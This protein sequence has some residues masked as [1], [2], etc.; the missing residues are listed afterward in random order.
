MPGQGSTGI[1]RRRALLLGAAALGGGL[2]RPTGAALARDSRPWGPYPP[3]AIEPVADR[4]GEVVVEDPYRWLEADI[5]GSERLRTWTTAQNATADAYLGSLDGRD[6]IRARLDALFDIETVGPLSN[7]G[8]FQFF[9]RRGRSEEQASLWV[10]QG[11]RGEA[12]RL[13]D[14]ARWSDAGTTAL[15]GFAVSQN[16][17]YVAYAQQASGSD[18]RVWR[19]LDRESGDTLSDEIRWNKYSNVFWSPDGA[20]FY[21]TRFPEPEALYLSSN[22]GQQLYFH[23]LGDPQD[24]DRL[25]YEDPANPDYMFI[26]QLSE[27]GRYLVVNTGYAGGGA[28]LLYK[29]L[30]RPQADFV[31]VDLGPVEALAGSHFV[32]AQGTTL[33]ILT[34]IGAPNGRLVSVDAAR[35]GE[36]PREV[37]AEGRYPLRSVLRSGDRLFL[38]YLEDGS[39][40]LATQSL[41]DG[42]RREVVLPGPGVVQGLT[43]AAAGSVYYQYSGFGQPLTT[44]RYDTSRGRSVVIDQPQGPVVPSDYQVEQTIVTARDG[45]RVPLFLACRKGLKKDGDAPTILYGYGGF[46]AAYPPDF[47]PEQVAWMDL[48]GVFAIAALPGDGVYG[49]VSHRAGALANK[50]AVFD[51]FN[52][53]AQHLIDAGLTRPD[54]LAAFGYSNGGL[55]VGGAVAR[56]PDLYAVALPTVGVLDMLRF[57]QFTNG[58]LWIREYGDP[59]DPALFPILHGYSP[60]HAVSAGQRYPALLIGTGDTDDRVAPMHS[61][62][63]AA[64]LQTLADPARPVLLTIDKDSGHGA[65]NSRSKTAKAAAD[66]LAFAAHHLGLAVPDRFAVPR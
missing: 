19:V 18:W 38:R 63:Y 7:A 16:G 4:Y 49:E 15:A 60:Y 11:E 1:N 36:A 55:L 34:S 42:A 64:R 26:G 52:D 12:Q 2:L 58:R 27:D 48:G 50:P 6:R 57:P 40:R 39:D 37:V 33:Y 66:R 25:I 5:R 41:T 22:S 62:K 10:R 61:F 53:C 30:N 8:G 43:S 17:R 31:S 54:R 23:R 28:T 14:P 3:T 45:N 24:L 20:G 65:G 59:Q 51:A 32:G 21:Y 35:P 13:L 47:R 56:R 29:D 46:G 44:Y 9:L